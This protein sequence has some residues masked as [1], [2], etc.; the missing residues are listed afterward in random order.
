MNTN[1]K[2]DIGL[3][4]VILDVTKKGFFVFLPFSDTTSVDLIIADKSMK[5][6]RTQIKY[7]SINK[8]GVLTISTA[9]VVNGKKVPVDLSTT[10]I[11]AIY[12]PD[13]NE[14]YYISA[15]ELLG[16]TALCLRVTEPKVDNNNNIHYAKDYLDLNKVWNV[17]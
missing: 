3:A 2:G 5:I 11:W 10:D 7:I 9:N 1:K 16:K 12:C 15:V 6:I 4:N 8:T 13:N 17:T 14:I